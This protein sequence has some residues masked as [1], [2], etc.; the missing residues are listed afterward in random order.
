LQ[1]IQG[2]KIAEHDVVV[3]GKDK[4]YIGSHKTHAKGAE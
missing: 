2:K 1:L 3:K 4:A